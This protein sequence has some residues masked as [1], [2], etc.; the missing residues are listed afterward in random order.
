M[1]RWALRS[2]A[3]IRRGLGPRSVIVAAAWHGDERSP[4]LHVQAV[5]IDSQGRLGWAHVQEEWAVRAGLAPPEAEPPGEYFGKVKREGKWVEKAREPM[6]AAEVGRSR[7]RRSAEMSALQDF[8]HERAG[9]RYGLDRG[10]RGSRRRHQAVDRARAARD[11][12]EASERHAERVWERA[13]LWNAKALKKF[14]EVRVLEAS[15]E[16]MRNNRS[17]VRRQMFEAQFMCGELVEERKRLE[18]EVTLENQRLERER[19]LVLGGKEERQELVSEIERLQDL[20]TVGRNKLEDDY[21]QLRRDL[22][23]A[24][25]EEKK[26]LKEDLKDIGVKAQAAR[27]ALEQLER[28]QAEL[29]CVAKSLREE[30]EGFIAQGTALDERERVLDGRESRLNDENAGS[31]REGVRTGRGELAQV[32][33]K[34]VSSGAQQRESRL[35]RFEARQVRMRKR[36]DAVKAVKGSG[37][38][39]EGPGL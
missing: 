25:G 6:S 31:F 10:Q 24:H 15:Y 19:G 21:T 9:A 27:E 11:R 4:H 39:D 20:W 2:L 26:R 36:E 30:S 37:R 34:T 16:E 18:R 14:E 22:R 3:A 13:A 7:A 35:D 1:R 33:A 23:R 17:D 29:E 12:A 8:M 38:A 32:E 28:S 5:P